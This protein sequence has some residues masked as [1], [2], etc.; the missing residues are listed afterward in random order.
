MF[1]KTKML[2]AALLILPLNL[3]AQNYRDET[4]TGPASMRTGKIT[5]RWDD[6]AELSG[7]ASK[8]EG[9]NLLW[10]RQSA[11]VWEEALPIGNGRLGGMVFGGVAD[12]RIQLNESTLWNGY[13]L[14]P[15]NPESLTA[16]PEVRRLI[17]EGKNNEAVDLAGK[18]MMGRPKGVKAYQSLGELWFDTPVLTA[19]GY[20]RSL[21]LSTAI[22]CCQVCFRWGRVCAR[23]LFFAGRWNYCRAIYRKQERNDNF[24]SYPKA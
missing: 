2:A 12:E 21:D 20:T 18:T 6:R 13:P 16:L 11:K 8:P 7:T 10:Y 17:F 9:R 22:N 5:A 19:S 24:K 1:N 4:S 14:D 23:M 15:N 3:V